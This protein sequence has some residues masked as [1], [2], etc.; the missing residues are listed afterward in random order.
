MIKV[1]KIFRICLIVTLIAGCSKVLQTVELQQTPDETIQD[2]FNVIE[3]VPHLKRLE[4]KTNRH[5]TV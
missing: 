3:K 2:E 4:N 1:F 5:T